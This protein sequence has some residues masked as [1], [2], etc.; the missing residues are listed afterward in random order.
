MEG[1]KKKT[2]ISYPYFLLNVC[3]THFVF[4]RMYKNIFTRFN[5][6]ESM[7]IKGFRLMTLKNLLEIANCNTLSFDVRVE[8]DRMA[9]YQ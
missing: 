5:H 3:Q 7:I 1:L 4:C 8:K 6:G 2:K 9:F